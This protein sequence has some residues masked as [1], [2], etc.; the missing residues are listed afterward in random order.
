[1][2][3]ERHRSPS[4]G[5]LTLIPRF[6]AGKAL[7]IIERDRVTVFEGVPTMYAAMLHQ[8]SATRPTPP[9]CEVCVSGGAAMPVE[10]MRAFEEKF[11]C[12]V[13]EGYGLSETSPVASFNRR[14]RE[15]KPGS[16]GLPVDGVEMRSST[17][18][19]PRCP[20]ATSARSRSAATT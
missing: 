1:M 7:E 13:L 19:A 6:D 17:T 20:R 11:D 12:T 8:P 2:R 18:T 16:I 15:R 3:A 14:D 4:A 10:V 9:R 5:R